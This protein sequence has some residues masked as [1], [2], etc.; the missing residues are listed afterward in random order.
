MVYAYGT[1]DP[2]SP[3]NMKKEVDKGSKSVLLLNKMDRRNVD[4]TGWT[5]FTITANVR[6]DKSLALQK[7][8]E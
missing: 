5:K 7:V 4:K 3:M 2:V 6:F 8:R 1:E